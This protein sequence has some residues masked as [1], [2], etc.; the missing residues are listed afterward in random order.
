MAQAQIREILKAHGKLSI[1]ADALSAD[2][3]LYASGLT[4][5]TTVNVMLAIEDAFD[6]EFSDDMLS[7][8][9]F[10]SIA[11]MQNAV[12]DLLG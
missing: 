9:T 11:A 5:L 4:S 3:D 8:K 6:I 2:A 10:Q 1:D 7:R 12:E